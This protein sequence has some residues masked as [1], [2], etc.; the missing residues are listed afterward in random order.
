MKKYHKIYHF[1]KKITMMRINK[2][3]IY[4]KNNWFNQNNIEKLKK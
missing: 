4:N 3:I 2:S 1:K